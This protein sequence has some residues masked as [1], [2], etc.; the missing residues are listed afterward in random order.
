MPNNELLYAR[1]KGKVPDRYWYALN[2]KTSF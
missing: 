2:G 1:A